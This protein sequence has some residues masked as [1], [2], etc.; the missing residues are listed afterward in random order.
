MRL[1]QITVIVPVYNVE[2]YLRRCVDSILVQTFRDFELILVDDGS[3]DRCGEICDEYAARDSR[4]HVIHQA[5]GGLS[6][7]R[8]A[9]LDW[10]FA[11]STSRYVTF[12]DSD[13]CVNK[14][15]FYAMMRGTQL[16][17]RIVCMEL[18]VV[19]KEGKVN[20]EYT[21][22]LDWLMA[23]PEEYWV[24]LGRFASTACG[25]LFDVELYSD[26]RFP[27][28]KIHEDE[29]TTYLIL[30]AVPRLA[31][32]REKLYLYCRRSDSIMGVGWTE[33]SLDSIEALREQI[34]YFHRKGAKDAEVFSAK[35]LAVAYSDAIKKGRHREMRK[36]FRRL[37]A[38][39][40][41]PI[42]QNEQLYRV[43]CP[44]RMAWQWP[45][46][47]LSDVIRRH[48]L[49]GAVRQFILGGK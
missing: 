12:I 6:A 45:L 21:S 15:Y 33:R 24:K 28:G 16:G 35:R 19:L 37:L 10:M 11:H 4:V 46:H 38:D 7:A 42:L 20:C 40:N 31:Y 13:D 26:V 39:F 5:N 32:S 3:P 17:C 36:P 14:E 29:Y 47:R 23:S 44:I 2:P 49:F 9:A 27:L 1:P 18:E 34:A 41:F 30:F 22:T 8:N 48:G 43:A 25:K